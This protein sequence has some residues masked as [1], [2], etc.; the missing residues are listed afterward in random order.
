MGKYTQ[1]TLRNLLKTYPGKNN[2]W[3]DTSSTIHY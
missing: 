3:F 1:I 2:R